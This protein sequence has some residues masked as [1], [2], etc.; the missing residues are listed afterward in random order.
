[1]VLFIVRSEP[2]VHVQRQGVY[3]RQIPFAVDLQMA[4]VGI[5]DLADHHVL[6]RVGHAMKTA[7]NTTP[8]TISPRVSRV[9]RL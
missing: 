5:G 4:D 3:G 8:M 9:R 6:E 2:E 1:M 7:T